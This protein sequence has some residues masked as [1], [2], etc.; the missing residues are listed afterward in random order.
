MQ[1][2][3]EVLGFI[4]SLTDH[5]NKLRQNNVIFPI[6]FLTIYGQ[7]CSKLRHCDYRINAF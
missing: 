4:T 1:L 3:N 7:D 6:V 5:H 2:K